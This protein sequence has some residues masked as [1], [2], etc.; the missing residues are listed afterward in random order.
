MLRLTAK[1]D[2]NIP[3]EADGIAPDRLATLSSADVA[4]LPLQH[5]NVQV[6]LGDFFTVEGDAADQRIEMEGDCRR[7]KMIGS[8]MKSGSIVIRGDAGMH[9]GADMSGG[10]I[11]V[12]GDVGDWAAAEMRG[13]RIHIHG[14]A[15]HQ[16][17]SGY[18]GARLGMRGGAILVDGDAGNEVGANMRRGTIAVGGK[19]GDF[20][21]IGLIAGSIFVFGATGQRL[22]AGMKRGTIV[23]FGGEPTLLPTFT[24]ACR[25]RPVFVNLYLQRL[26]VWGFR[27]A[28]DVRANQYRRYCGDLLTGGK[29]EVLV[30]ESDS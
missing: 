17:G 24:Y 7:V 1:F 27:P 12:H 11:E 19:V 3:I 30:W 14:S 15:G 28:G 13:G 29:G 16:L 20:A 23:L 6:P 4:K 21:G 9:L 10:A 22:G 25:Q 5:G 2:T 26:A 8:N 18:R